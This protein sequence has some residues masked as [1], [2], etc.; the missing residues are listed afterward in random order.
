MPYFSVRILEK[1]ITCPEW[2][3]TLLSKIEEV[4][5]ERAFFGKKQNSTEGTKKMIS[6]L[7]PGMSFL[8][9]LRGEIT[10]LG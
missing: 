9:K 4:P 10:N 2:S 5:Q 1:I 6:F 7:Y 8:W 3:G